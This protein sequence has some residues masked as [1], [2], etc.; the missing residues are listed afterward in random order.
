MKVYLSQGVMNKKRLL[1]ENTLIEGLSKGFQSY[2]FG[3]TAEKGKKSSG[4][5]RIHC[6]YDKR[7]RTFYCLVLQYKKQIFKKCT[8]TNIQKV[9]KNKYSKSVQDTIFKKCTRNKYSKNKKPLPITF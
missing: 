4:L 2:S 9:Y 7:R 1:R 5:A 3:V 6:V 8:R